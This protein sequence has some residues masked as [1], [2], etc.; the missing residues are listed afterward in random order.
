MKMLSSILALYLP[1]TTAAEKLSHK[2]FSISSH[3]DYPDISQ[4]VRQL[5][6]V[7][8]KIK[9]SFIISCFIMATY[10]P[11]TCTCDW[12][13]KNTLLSAF[14]CHY[15]SWLYQQ[16]LLQ[17]ITKNMNL[18][19]RLEVFCFSY[20]KKVVFLIFLLSAAVSS[21]FSICC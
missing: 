8:A 10:S 14:S 9:W 4:V 12:L 2:L 20:E 19:H 11:N 18:Q 3:L 21:L 13:A 15:P 6:S 1:L 7:R 16:L 5:F 17:L